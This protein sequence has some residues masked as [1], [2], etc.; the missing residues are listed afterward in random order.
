MSLTTGIPGLPGA[1]PRPEFCSTSCVQAWPPASRGTNWTAGSSTRTRSRRASLL[2]ILTL[3]LSPF[4]G[5]T[6]P[7]QRLVRLLASSS[8]LAVTD[9]GLS[10]LRRFAPRRRFLLTPFDLTGTLATMRRKRFRSFT[11][12]HGRRRAE[13]RA[14]PASRFSARRFVADATYGGSEFTWRASDFRDDLAV[15]ALA[16]PASAAANP[17]AVVIKVSRTAIERAWGRMES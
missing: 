4:G 16:A 12:A 8:R 1:P 7:P 6:P 15:G 3:G 11:E 13:R 10:A 5:L 2:R 9:A 17:N 14:W